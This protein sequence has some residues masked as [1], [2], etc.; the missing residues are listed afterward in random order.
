MFI[1][2]EHHNAIEFLVQ[3]DLKQ[4]HLL[5]EEALRKNPAH[6]NILSDR[7]FL[8][9]HLK[10]FDL[11]LDDFDLCVEFQPEY[12]FRYAARAYAYVFKGEIEAAILDYKQA[13]FLDPRDGISHNNI[14]IL[15]DQIGQSSLS[16]IHF[17]MADQCMNRSGVQIYENLES[18]AK[19]VDRE[20]ISPSDLMRNQESTLDNMQQIL[21]NPAAFKKFMFFLKN[22]FRNK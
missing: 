3:G 8:Y 16:E 13:L 4:A 7:G 6:P 18:G 2:Q 11:A 5:L 12:A 14:G 15:Y 22:G 21:G 9:L 20:L 19:P 1:N 17:K 10:E